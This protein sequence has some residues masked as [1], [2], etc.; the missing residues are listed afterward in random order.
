MTKEMVIMLVVAVLAAI[1]A[2][3][4]K[5]AK[6]RRATGNV[7]RK[8]LLT[9]REQPMF[10]RLQQ[11][12]P[13]DVVLCQVAFSALVTSNDRPTPLNVQPEGC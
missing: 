8:Q 12:F 5:G 6:P 10:F 1:G 3:M 9:E 4:L 7:S 11:A 2:A 13:N